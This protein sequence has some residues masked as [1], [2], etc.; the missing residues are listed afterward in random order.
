[1]TQ[2]R[3]RRCNGNKQAWAAVTG[4]NDWLITTSLSLDRLVASVS[5]RYPDAQITVQV[6]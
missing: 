5:D 3:I 6:Q 4:P 1:M 2:I